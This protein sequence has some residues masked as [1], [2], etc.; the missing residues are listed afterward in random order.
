M[1]S[2][3]GDS[4]DC[5]KLALMVYKAGQAWGGDP[6][7]VVSGLL[8]GLTERAGVFGD[9]DPNYRVGVMRRDTYY[10]NSFASGGF[11]PQYQGPPGD[12][13]VRHFVAW[14]GAGFNVPSVLA[15]QQLYSQEGTSDPRDPDV[16]LGLAGIELANDYDIG[17][18]D[19]YKDLA[20]RIWRDICGGKGALKLP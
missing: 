18:Y 19:S 7:R 2:G 13:Q 5:L 9:S 12:N 4:N 15:R 6:I 8:N 17:N 3:N 20:Q 14:F 11:L 16:A 1:L 10:G